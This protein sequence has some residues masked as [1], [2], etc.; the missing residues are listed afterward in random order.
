MIDFKG[1][2]DD[3]QTLLEFAYNKCYCL[4]IQVSPYEALIGEDIDILLGSRCSKVDRIRSSS[5]SHEEGEGDLIKVEDN[6]ESTKSY[7]DVRR[8]ILE[9]EVKDCIYLK[10]S[11]M[12]VVMR[13]CRKG[14]LS[15]CYIGPY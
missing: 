1:N 14:K 3:P 4:S 9:F 7:I 11:Q 15:L 8:R 2:L 10:V 13:F 5:P 6:I 12:K